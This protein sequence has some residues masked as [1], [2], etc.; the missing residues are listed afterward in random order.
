ML[1]RSANGVGGDPAW[2]QLSP[3]G[4]QP[5][6]RQGSPAVY[7]AATNRMTIFGGSG[8]TSLL[9]N[10]VW[11]LFDANGVGGL[12]VGS[13]NVVNDS[14]GDGVPDD[15]DN[16]PTVSNPDQKDSNF[17]GI[18]DACRTPGLQHS[19]A[20]F[21]QAN[22]NGTTTVQAQALPVAQE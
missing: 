18:G 21:L 22:I 14:D 13:N 17:N 2:T 1:F 10:D 3:S 5:P 8:N 11:V 4:I 15:L 20:N 12:T 6:A 7:D 19:T 9:L 16:C